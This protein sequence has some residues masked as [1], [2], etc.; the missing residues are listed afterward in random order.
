MT[1]DGRCAEEG[2]CKI[3]QDEAY[4]MQHILINECETEFL[5]A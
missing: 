3:A 4:L 2:K 1:V 5:K